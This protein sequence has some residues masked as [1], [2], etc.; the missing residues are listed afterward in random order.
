MAALRGLGV[1]TVRG[2]CSGRRPC[3]F[4]H[5]WGPSSLDRHLSATWSRIHCFS[6]I[7]LSLHLTRK[8]ST[9]LQT[10]CFLTQVHLHG[11]MFFTKQGFTAYVLNGSCLHGMMFWGRGAGGAASHLPT[12]CSHD[13]MVLQLFSRSCL[14]LVFPYFVVLLVCT[15]TIKFREN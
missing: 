11:L 2:G 8:T 13:C 15:R 5:R 6:Q 9:H 3:V 7:P 12:Q 10:H 14:L 4:Y 1:K